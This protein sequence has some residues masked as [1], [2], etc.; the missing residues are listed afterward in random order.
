ME[1]V[2]LFDKGGVD[3]IFLHSFNFRNWFGSANDAL[4]QS[5]IRPY[6]PYTTRQR[7]KSF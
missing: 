6:Y 4:S 5:L 1:H 3:G 7:K 2:E